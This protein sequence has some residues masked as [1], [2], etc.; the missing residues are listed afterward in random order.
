MRDL[1]GPVMVQRTSHSVPSSTGGQAGSTGEQVSRH[2][3]PLLRPANLCQLEVGNTIWVY[4][5]MAP[6]IVNLT[7]WWERDDANEIRSSQRWVLQQEEGLAHVA[8][9][10][11]GEMLAEAMSTIELREY[12]A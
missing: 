11:V 10:V 5:N 2:E 9:H 3:E 12:P 4:R 8:E 1:G 6:A 7:P